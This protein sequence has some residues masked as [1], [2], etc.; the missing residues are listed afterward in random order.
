M[1]HA[2][3][4]EPEFLP[5]RFEAEPAR[6][7][8]VRLDAQQ[9]A[10]A[11]FLDQRA[12]PAQAEGAW[13]P[14]A[15]VVAQQPAI[16]ADS[17]VVDAVFHIGHCGSTLL[18]RLL[19]CWPE[20]EA[21]R[22]PLPLRT[23]AAH[24]DAPEAAVAREALPVLLGYW[25]RP[26]PP[27]SRVAIKAT[28]GCNRLIEPMLRDAGLGRALLLDIPLEPYLATLLKADT[29]L[30]DAVAAAAER[31]GVLATHGI[32]DAM[33]HTDTADPV[34][35]CALGWLAEQVRFSAL[36]QGREGARVLRVDFEDLLA[37]PVD[38]LH[39]IAA[40]LA[41]DPA[42]VAR[43]LQAPAW[44]RYSKAEEHG[45]SR[46]DRA[47]DLALSRRRFGG[48]IAA[49]RAAVERVLAHSPTLSAGLAPL[50]MG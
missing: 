15:D 48:A 8:F 21:L 43:A 29:S 3:L 13:L 22:E 35:A 36:T 28:S 19:E 34:V 4:R 25:R 2:L 20:I 10:A 12:L 5:F 42:G 1:P 26:L 40:H 18:S 24:W 46:E 11:A 44:G 50:R 47:H 27:R 38:T 31:L 39:G 16:D 23:I 9:R 41:L 30:R 32:A 7:L 45:Y 33:A 17:A 6:A 14:W 37:T 49:G